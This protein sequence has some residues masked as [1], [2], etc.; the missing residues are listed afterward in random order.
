MLY[1]GRR[2]RVF[3]DARPRWNEKPNALDAYEH[4][5]TNHNSS[6]SLEI[7]DEH[8]DWYK[9]TKINM[10]LANEHWSLDPT[11]RKFK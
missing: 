1:R 6:V 8:W 4:H 2:G 3:N 11:Y 5:A 9:A 7:F 10:G